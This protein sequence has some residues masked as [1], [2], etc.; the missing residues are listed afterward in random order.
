MT[1]FGI[2]N[3]LVVFATT[4]EGA[5]ENEYLI[6]LFICFY[7]I[8]LLVWFEIIRAAFKVSNDS[9]QF[10]V[11]ILTGSGIQ[12]CLILYLLDYLPEFLIVVIGVP[13]FLLVMF[14]PFY[15]LGKIFERIKNRKILG[16]PTDENRRL[17]LKLFLLSFV[18]S[19]CLMRWVMI[20]VIQV[21]AKNSFTSS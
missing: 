5:K 16:E 7:V 2:F 19:I 1:V 21:F 11:F 6:F 13:V 3:A 9:F 20:P 4:M 18:V 8:S 12:I 15:L 10:H 17:M 14:G